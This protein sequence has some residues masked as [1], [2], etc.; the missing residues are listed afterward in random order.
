MT[1]SQTTPRCNGVVRL[2]KTGKKIVGESTQE[3]RN[4]YVRTH[5]HLC[6]IDIMNLVENHELHVS[7]EVRTLV[8]HA[9]E[10]L[11]SHD[12][13]VRLRVDLDIPG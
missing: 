1:S 7:D 10:N 3:K 5:T 9:P 8:K 4:K 2:N 11:G 6:I 13:A 12:Q